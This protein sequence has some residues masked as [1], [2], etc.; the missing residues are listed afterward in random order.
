MSYPHTSTDCHEHH[1]LVRDFPVP[2]PT[3][4][5]L[6]GSTR[7]RDAFEAVAAELTLGGVIVVKPDVFGNDGH[8]DKAHLPAV[9]ADTKQ[10]LDQ[11]HFRKIDLADTCYVV[12]PEGY[13]GESTRREIAYA[14]ALGKS[15]RY[16]V[17]PGEM[18]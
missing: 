16:L 13:I 12:N 6:C 17:D 9:D 7:F 1:G 18:A 4:T 8:A 11:L 10:A 15:I 2:R 14:T 5:V 3:I